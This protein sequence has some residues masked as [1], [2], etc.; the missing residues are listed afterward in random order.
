VQVVN[1]RLTA[2]GDPEPLDLPPLAAAPKADPAVA[3]IGER[4]VWFDEPAAFVATPVYRRERL[5]AGHTLAGPA[6]VEQMDSTTVVLP[7]QTATVDA[8]GNLV[9]RTDGAPAP[10]AAP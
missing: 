6:I 8:H 7:G 1:V 4:P 5:L 9:I 3:R 10:P 2:L